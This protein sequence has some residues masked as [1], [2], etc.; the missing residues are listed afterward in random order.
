M[1]TP[2]KS[3]AVVGSGI[4]GLSAAWL[5]RRDYSVTL[6]ERNDYLGGHTH[7]LLVEE[8]DQQIPVDTGFIVYNEPNY[9]HLSRLFAQLGI[10]TQDT[11]M[12]FGVSVGPGRLEYAGDNLDTLFAQRRNLLRKDFLHMLK[13][14]LRFNR[15]CK[16]LLKRNG[17][18]EISL[19]EFLD[20]YGYATGFRDH[21]LLPMAAAIWSCPTTAMLDF[22]AASFARFFDNHGLLS[23]SGRPQWRTVCGGSWSYVKKLAA[24]LHNTTHIANPVLAVRRDAQGVRLRL[25]DGQ[26]MHFDAVV[27][28]CHA[29]EALGLLENPSELERTLLSAFHYQTNR[30]WLH[31]DTALMPHSRKV[32][33]AW[34]YLASDRDPDSSVSV[35]VTYWM[36]R[37]Q[38]LNSRCNYLVS[39]NPLKPPRDEQVIAEMSYEH[40][41]FDQTAMSAQPRLAELQGRDRIWFCGSYFGYGFHE[42]ALR[43][44]V[45]VARALGATIPWEADAASD[46]GP[47]PIGRVSGLADALG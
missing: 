13:E 47:D 46:R 4:A 40:P 42:D 5:V 1:D 36:N 18:G 31:T 8:E 43:S 23:L 35:S 19:G 28:A 25:A 9:P 6:I 17:L 29:D 10:K 39:L 26:S 3:L 32:W 37:L 12:S 41:V 24:Q 16:G 27:L 44:S 14:I 30:A 21:Y 45:Q 2:R 20:R 15:Q 11:D 38:R 33:S 34:N 7:T 22:P